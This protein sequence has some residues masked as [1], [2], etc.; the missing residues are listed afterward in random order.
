M[1]RLSNLGKQFA[2]SALLMISSMSKS[3][4]ETPRRKAFHDMGPILCLSSAVSKVRIFI[5]HRQT[6]TI[7]EKLVS[8]IELSTSRQDNMAE[9]QRYLNTGL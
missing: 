4:C 1:S 8:N 9:I 7:Y 5:C 3:V 2:V 6:S